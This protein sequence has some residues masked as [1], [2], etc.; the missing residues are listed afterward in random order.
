MH[1]MGRSLTFDLVLLEQVSNQ[2]FSRVGRW[3][4]LFLGLPATSSPN[5]HSLSSL[6]S[7]AT[8]ECGEPHNVKDLVQI[9]PLFGTASP[10]WTNPD[11]SLLVT[12]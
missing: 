8:V 2:T 4:D 1:W 11:T 7:S 6:F 5:T 3:L 10:L 9:T 12:E